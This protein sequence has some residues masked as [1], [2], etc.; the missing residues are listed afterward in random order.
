VAQEDPRR[1]DEVAVELPGAAVGAG[2][3][4][5]RDRATTSAVARSIELI[6]EN[7][8]RPEEEDDDVVKEVRRVREQIFKDAGGTLE[9]LY[10]RLK[11]LEKKETIPV[12][13]LPPRLAGK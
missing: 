6:G 10:R 13:N 1:A 11:E 5:D 3:S 2:S 12:V 9:G 4:G 8:M 7:V